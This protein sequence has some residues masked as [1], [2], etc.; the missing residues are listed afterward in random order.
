MQIGLFMLRRLWSKIRTL[1]GGTGTSKGADTGEPFDYRSYWNE[2][3]RQGGDSGKGSYDELAAYKA[4]YLNS[5]LE[6]YGVHRVVEFGCG[7][8]NQLGMIR[9]PEY[10]GFDIAP[11][12]VERCRERYARDDAKRFEVYVPGQLDR[13]SVGAPDMVV[14]LD[15]LYHIV[16]EAD[17]TLTLDD[18]FGLGARVVVLYTALRPLDDLTDATLHIRDWDIL[19]RLKRYPSYAVADRPPHPYGDTY[20]VEFL[21]LRKTS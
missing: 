6:K 8:G 4:E 3:Y 19:E 2:R 21:C 17:L 14:C 15:V 18:I 7:D 12:A 16:D 9:Y 5:I 13:Q 20:N 11:A 1:C 10:L